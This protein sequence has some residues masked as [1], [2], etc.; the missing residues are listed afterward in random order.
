MNEIDIDPDLECEH[1]DASDPV[2]AI[3][4]RI[5][6]H[7]LLVTG[8]RGDTDENDDWFYSDGA[9][10]LLRDADG[11]VALVIAPTSSESVRRAPSPLARILV[12]LRPVLTPAEQR[13]LVARS[14]QTA[15][16]TLDYLVLTFIAALLASFGLLASSSAVIIGAMLVAPLISPLMA[17]AVSGVTGRFRSIGRASNALIQGFV[18]SFAVAAIIGYLSR[19][20]IVTPEM[21]ARGNPTLVD[22]GV[23][24]GAGMVAAYANARKGIPAALAGV[25]I[26][27]ALMPPICT[28]GLSFAMRDFALFQGSFLLFA[29]N[30]SSIVIAA[31]LTFFY[32]GMRPRSKDEARHLPFASGLIVVVFGLV[33]VLVVSLVL[34]PIAT[35][36]IEGQLRDAF[37]GELVDVEVRRS[38]PLEVIVTIRRDADN[39]LSDSVVQEVERR[40]AANLDRDLRLS[41]I[42][43]PVFG[44]PIEDPD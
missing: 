24:L 44:A 34:T 40:L 22:L 19:S 5:D 14:E 15:G 2:G 12:W 21:A 27:A 7:D 9:T 37:A 1:V 36:R 28:V 42:V 17:F 18:I 33:L 30:I 4:A 20:Q 3:F 39:P 23:A 35:A 26:A 6:K 16:P 25:A 8:Y 43:Q 10:A 41:V 31:W 13:E 38:E 29:V 32:L 11:P